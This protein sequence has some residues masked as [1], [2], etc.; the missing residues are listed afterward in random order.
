MIAVK[1]T[2]ARVCFGGGGIDLRCFDDGFAL[3]IITMSS[4]SPPSTCCQRSNFDA[5]VFHKS[6]DG[7]LSVVYVGTYIMP[8]LPTLADRIWYAYQCLARSPGGKPPSWREL[9]EQHDI[10]AGTFS[11]AA[12]GRRTRFERDTFRKIAAAL[13]VTEE[14]LDFGGS[15][16]PNPPAGVIIPPRPGRMSQCYGELDGWASAVEQARTINPGVPNEAFLAGAELP[17]SRPVEEVTPA[18]AVGVALFAWSTASFDERAK[19][20]TMDAKLA[21]AQPKPRAR[22]LARKA[23]K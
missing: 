9:E 19:F 11:H 6:L 18:I 1:S 21:E 5:Q 10:A 2:E 22:A 8:R 4:G 23:A 12:K 13:R 14:W 15:N 17:V 20:S 16:A 3:F 7:A